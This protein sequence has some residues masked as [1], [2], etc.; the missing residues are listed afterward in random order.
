V[1]PGDLIFGDDDGVV[2]VPRDDAARLADEVA[3]KLAAER[4]TRSSWTDYPP[5]DVAD[6]LRDRGYDFE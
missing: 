3:P 1:A 5:F 6:E 2:V 4:A